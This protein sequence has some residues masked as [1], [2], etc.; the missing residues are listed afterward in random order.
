M[1]PKTNKGLPMTNKE[2]Q[3]EFGATRTPEQM[4]EIRMENCETQHPTWDERKGSDADLTL[5]VAK[6]LIVS[7]SEQSKLVIKSQEKE[8]KTLVKT[9]AD[10]LAKTLLKTV[11]KAGDKIRKAVIKSGD[12]LRRKLLTRLLSRSRDASISD[13]EQQSDYDSESS[14][15][16]EVCQV[17]ESSEGN[18]SERESLEGE[19]SSS[20]VESEESKL[21]SDNDIDAILQEE[22]GWAPG[23]QIKLPLTRDSYVIQCNHDEPYVLTAVACKHIQRIF[24]Q[25]LNI[26]S[27]DGLGDVLKQVQNFLP[28][29][30]RDHLRFIFR[31]HHFLQHKEWHFDLDDATKAKLEC[32]VVQVFFALCPN[33]EF[34]HY[35]SGARKVHQTWEQFHDEKVS[36]LESSNC[37]LNNR[38]DELEDYIHLLQARATEL[39]KRHR[40]EEEDDLSYKRS[41]N[42]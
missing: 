17:P 22:K 28:L 32:A 27:P 21:S 40:E 1:A 39:R 19:E 20:E 11:A 18:V 38:I 42:N 6:L 3:D 12:G 33:V 35:N 4:E 10:A 23:T 9:L 30:V 29:D 13:A 37:R 14:E 36:N 31:T 2:R 26:K 15:E 25:T 8:M 16:G 34:K 24:D 5:E 41:K 7:Q